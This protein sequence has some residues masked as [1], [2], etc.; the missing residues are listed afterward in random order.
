MNY[1]LLILLWIIWCSLHSLLVATGTTTF[2]KRHLGSMAAYYRILYNLF[3]IATMIPM[4]RWQRELG[5]PV[6]IELYGY[7]PEVRSILKTFGAVLMAG[8]FLSFDVLELLGIRQ[9]LERKRG[10]KTPVISKRGLYGFVRH[11]M[12]LGAI[13][14]L[15][16]AAVNVPLGQ[17]LGYS[18]L[19]VY[20][21]I[22]AFNEDR[23]LAREL[24]EIY[25]SYQK[26]VPIL[27][28]RILSTKKGR[29][30]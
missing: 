19:A 1:I 24:G 12:Y 16:S 7:M 10:R 14:Y 20:V 28:P 5:G 25:R 18:L 4:L 3:A 29:K 21:V 11:P 23:R 30:S 22:G 2:F 13:I 6:V 27:L 9:V 8:A 15:A 26:E 17:F